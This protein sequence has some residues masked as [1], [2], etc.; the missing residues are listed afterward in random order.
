MVDD[1]GNKMDVALMNGVDEVVW[2]WFTDGNEKKKQNERGADIA[3]R[4]E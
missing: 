3:K 1:D 2:Y 4:E